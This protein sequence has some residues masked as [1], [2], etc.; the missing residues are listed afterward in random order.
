MIRAMRKDRNLFQGN[1][2]KKNYFE[3]WYYKQVSTDGKTAISFIPGISLHASDPHCFVQYIIVDETLENGISTGYVRFP[4]ESFVWNDE[5]FAVKIEDNFFSESLVSVH[6]ESVT[7]TISGNLKLGPLTPIESTVLSPTIMG[8][9]AYIPKMEC[10]HGVTSMNHHLDGSLEINGRTV[11]FSNGKGYIEK[12]W[13]TKFPKNYV[14]LQSNHF[15]E[16]DTSLFFSMAYIPFYVRDFLDFISNIQVNGKEYRFAT[17][18]NSKIKLSLPYDD[19]VLVT[20]ENSKAKVK[21]FGKAEHM[22]NLQAPVLSGMDKTIKEG[23]SGTIELE[24]WDKENNT[25]YQGIGSMAGVEIVDAE[26]L[27]M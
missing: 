1:L 17:Y 25:H 8:P 15:D 10:Y 27:V 14:W 11:A 16:P 19:T 4:V 12:D 6:L 3:G 20:M 13:G 2:N 21:I 18:N 9:F 24:L 23:V 26:D 7:D 5:P 22:G